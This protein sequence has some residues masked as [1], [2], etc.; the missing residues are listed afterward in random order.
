MF[1]YVIVSNFLAIS[2]AI[3]I[4]DPIRILKGGLHDG[5]PGGMF[6]YSIA[7]SDGQSSNYTWM[8]LIRTEQLKRFRQV[9]GCWK[10]MG[11]LSAFVCHKKS[12]AFGK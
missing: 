2:F 8:V 7:L 3:L 10:A 4:P 11:L 9:I 6:G 1:K 12:R 5:G